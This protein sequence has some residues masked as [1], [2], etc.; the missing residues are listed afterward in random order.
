MGLLHS[1]MLLREN[2]FVINK[3]I[4]DVLQAFDTEITKLEFKPESET[5]IAASKSKTIKI[6][7]LPK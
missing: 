4:V 5:L 2:Q 3:F 6:F 1:G 7:K